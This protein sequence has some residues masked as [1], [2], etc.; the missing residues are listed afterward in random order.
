MDGMVQNRTL[1]L[2]SESKISSDQKLGF[3]SGGLYYPI[4]IKAIGSLGTQ[5]PTLKVPILTPP[6]AAYETQ[7]SR[8]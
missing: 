7:E 1:R 3:R 5:Y 2:V 6:S 8:D 4:A